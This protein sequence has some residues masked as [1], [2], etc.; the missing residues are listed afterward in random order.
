M[1]LRQPPPLEYASPMGSARLPALLAVGLALCT[2]GCRPRP[3][4]RNPPPALGTP[5]RVSALLPS[6]HPL[7]GVAQLA[8]RRLNESRAPGER[9]VRLEVDPPTP[10][11]RVVVPV[12]RDAPEGARALVLIPRAEDLPEKHRA[13]PDL[14]AE[15]GGDDRRTAH[16]LA[17]YDAI[18]LAGL[19]SRA[20][21]D[22]SPEELL[23]WLRGS[24][25]WQLSLGTVDY[26]T[27]LSPAIG[28]EVVLQGS[29][30]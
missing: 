14:L 8:S 22:A 10:S 18:V 9:P 27:S 16:A 26:R 28:P 25:G 2:L 24:S 12:T 21:P 15:F 17:V 1:D 13:D 20:L 6:D 30:P 11:G 5:V 29:T 19:A 7:V 4:E 23:D 3:P